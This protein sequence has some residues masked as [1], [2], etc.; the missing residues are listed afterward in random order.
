M[1]GIILL[2]PISYYLAKQI[3]KNQTIIY[4]LTALIAI[5]GYYFEN[6]L[7]TQGE[8]AVGAFV[9]VMFA[10]ALNPTWKFT[11]Q[12]KLIRKELAIIGTILISAHGIHY[13]FSDLEIFGLISL[14]ILIPLAIISFTVIRK[15]MSPKTWKNIQRLSY[16]AYGT[17]YIHLF[18]VE[19]Y[20]MI[21]FGV[22][23]LIL[24]I[25]QYFKTKKK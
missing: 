11:K 25:M 24:K 18:F 20:V 13:L 17:I 7:V 4:S 19:S 3:H 6:P 14:I 15:K 10:G 16:L 2:G 1:L 12:L 5:L 8:F 22:L 23:Y 9:Y 21:P